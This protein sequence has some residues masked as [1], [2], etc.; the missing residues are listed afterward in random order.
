MGFFVA[1]R[2][3]GINGDSALTARAP[4]G[5]KRRASVAG[6]PAGL[7]QAGFSR[8]CERVRSK[9][10]WTLTHP[11]NSPSEDAVNLLRITMGAGSDP[12]LTTDGGNALKSDLEAQ[13]SAGSW[14]NFCDGYC[15]PSG[16]VIE[17]S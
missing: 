12:P 8:P 11:G 15:C 10:V 16:A 9:P 3:D 1:D 7:R 6:K 4:R 5:E 17:I 14:S 2:C 13:P